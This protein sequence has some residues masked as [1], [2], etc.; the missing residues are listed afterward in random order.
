MD[1]F[2]PLLKRLSEAFGPSGFED[3]VREIVIA[4]MEP[5]VDELFVDRW[6]NVYGVKHGKSD[7][8]AMVAAH[9]DEIGLMVDHVEKN[10]FLR[11]KPIGG[12][13][14]VTLVGQ[15]VVV[16]T[17]DGRKIPGVVG[18]RPPH[19]TQPGKEREAP[20]M[21]DIFVDI[22][23]SSAEEVEKLGVGVGSVAVLDREFAE[24]ANGAVTGKAFDDRVGLAVMLWALRRLRELPVTLYAVAT[25]QEE[26]GL[27]GAAVAAERVAPHYAVALDTTIAADVPGTSEREYVVR[28]GGGPAI[29]VMDGGRGGLF[30]AHPRLRDFVAEVAR[31]EGIPHQMEVLYGGTTDAMAIAFRREG[32]PAVAISIPARYVHSPVEVLRVDDAVNAARL[33][34]AVLENASPQFVESLMERRIK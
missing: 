13:N 17:R 21:K 27:R 32:V 2:K 22:G 3:E 25:V 8:R 1:D 7:Y 14:E 31:K 16:R 4:E 24:L 11:V 15:R 6:G 12:W 18:T 30:I 10:G 33:L 28:L 9:M 34:V 19:I 23:A 29:K 20:E 26:V 5:Y